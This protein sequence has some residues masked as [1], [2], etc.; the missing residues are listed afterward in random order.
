MYRL[1]LSGLLGHL[2]VSK[3][4]LIVPTDKVYP[5][6]NPYDFNYGVRVSLINKTITLGMDNSNT[7]ISQ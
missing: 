3:V 2:K 7:F 6:V 5:R 4:S 1:A